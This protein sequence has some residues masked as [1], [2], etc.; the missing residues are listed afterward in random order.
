MG[1]IPHIQPKKTQ[2][3]IGNAGRSLFRRKIIGKLRRGTFGSIL[4]FI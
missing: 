1:K 3:R 4:R 2:L